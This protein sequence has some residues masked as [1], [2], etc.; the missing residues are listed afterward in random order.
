MKTILAMLLLTAACASEQPLPTDQPIAGSVAVSVQALSNMSLQSVM[1]R[2]GLKFEVVKKEDG[3]W[4]S[5][6]NQSCGAQSYECPKITYKVGANR[7]LVPYQ[8]A[9]EQADS[10]R[11]FREFISGK[12]LNRSNAFCTVNGCYPADVCVGTVTP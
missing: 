2:L 11:M 10:V 1:T 8:V 3:R 5:R 7:Y 4:Y 6:P 12:C 9:A